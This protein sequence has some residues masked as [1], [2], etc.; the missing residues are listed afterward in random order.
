M[1]YASLLASKHAT[2]QENIT[3]VAIQYRFNFNVVGELNV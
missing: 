1:S 3:V 2:E